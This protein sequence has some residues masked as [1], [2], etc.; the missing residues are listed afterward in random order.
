MAF[1][2][3]ELVSMHLIQVALL[4]SVQFKAMH[5]IT[6]GE[7]EGERGEGRG[8]SLVCCVLKIAAYFIGG[9]EPDCYLTC[10]AAIATSKY[11]VRA[12]TTNVTSNVTLTGPQCD[13]VEHIVARPAYG[14]EECVGGGRGGGGECGGGR[15]GGGECGGGRSACGEGVVSVGEGGVHVGE[16]DDGEHLGLL[17]CSNVLM[18]LAPAMKLI[19]LFS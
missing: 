5:Y 13:V 11:V 16:G 1:T 2:T 19:V 6:G 14:G 10:K 4:R 18:V 3:D 9:C 8:G 15:G 12:H 7:G 17:A